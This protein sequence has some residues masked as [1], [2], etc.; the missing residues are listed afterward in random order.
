MLTSA[1]RQDLVIRVGLSSAAGEMAFGIES[2]G[3]PVMVSANSLFDH[4]KGC[5]RAVPRALDDLDWALDSAGFVAMARY[6]RFPWSVAQYV[7]LAMLSGC[8]W[9]SQMD[10]CC[11][12]E[13]AADRPTVLAR[14]SA[15][16]QLLSMCRDEYTRVIAESPE[17]AQ[18][19]P[20][21]MPILQGWTPEDYRVSASLTATV[22]DGVWPDLIG[23]GS[24][25]RR[26]LTGPDGLWR[27]LHEIDAVLPPHVR[28]HL[29]GVKGAAIAG[30]KEAHPRVASVDSMAFEFQ[31]RMD[32]MHSG[33]P[34]SVGRRLQALDRWVD[35]QAAHSNEAT[36]RAQMALLP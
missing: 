6:G 33:E 36:E 5:F 1:A 16:A 3:L 20:P 19:T 32:A 14:V 31:A 2:R 13:V 8:S 7:N 11:E 24:V 30:I 18:F 4:A 25:C 9:W 22:L 34:K 12:P 21:P 27:V 23:V 26:R 28:V 15:T 29:F 35:R 10:C 17:F